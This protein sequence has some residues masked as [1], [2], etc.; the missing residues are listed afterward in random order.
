MYRELIRQHR[1]EALEFRHVDTFNLDEYIGLDK[2]HE[3]SYRY[4][5]NKQLLDHI[6]VDPKRTHVPSGVAENPYKEAKEY[7][8]MIDAVGGIDLQLLGMGNNGHIGFNEPGDSFIPETHVTE[9]SESTIKANARFF[10]NEDEVPRMAIT[11]GFRHIMQSKRILFVVSG[12]QKAEV[13]MRALT[14][15]VNP[16]VPASILQL[17]PDLTVVA[18]RDAL[19]WMIKNA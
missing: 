13:L 18:D 11:L 12:K 6:D 16:E 4:F 1:E 3:Q 9:L 15:P 17:H 8:R 10:D 2:F 5:M 7:D 14:G 19:E